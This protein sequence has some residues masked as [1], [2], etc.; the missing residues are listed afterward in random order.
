MST[1]SLAKAKVNPLVTVEKAA[2]QAA[3]DRPRRAKQV[4]SN[5]EAGPLKSSMVN[6]VPAAKRM[7]ASPRMLAG[8]E[9]TNAIVG[10]RVTSTGFAGEVRQH[11]MPHL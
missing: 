7:V 4:P 9:T 1:L 5:K 2:N 11:P 10:T 8:P 3:T 6:A